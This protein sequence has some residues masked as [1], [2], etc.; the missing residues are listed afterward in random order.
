MAVLAVQQ[1]RRMRGGA[2][3]QL[4]LGADG[5]IYGGAMSSSS[6]SATTGRPPQIGRNSQI[7]PGFNDVD[8][9]LARKL[10]IHEGINLQ[11]SAEA[12]NLLNHKIITGVQGTYSAY[13]SATATSATC[14]TTT[15]APTGGVVQGCISPYTG[16]GISAFGAVSGT[17]NGL[18]GPRQMQVSAKLNF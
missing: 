5:N 10:V 8:F 15:T 11:L 7:G 2:Q 12:F 16:T 6:G 1:I 13:T 9:R 18:Y 17:N 14:N 4:M 3:G